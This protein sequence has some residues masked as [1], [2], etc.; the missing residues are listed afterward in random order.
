MRENRPVELAGNGA[1]GLRGAAASVMRKFSRQDAR[2]TITAAGLHH[3]H[4]SLLGADN[5]SS[6][7][8]LD[9]EVYC[10]I[11]CEVLGLSLSSFEMI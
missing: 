6:A 8:T 11:E 7:V 2:I 3:H 9:I 4:G 5:L 1:V 10:D